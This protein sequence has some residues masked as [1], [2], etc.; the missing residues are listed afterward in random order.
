MAKSRPKHL[1]LF[2]IRLPLPGVISIMHRVFGAA[3]F[4]AIPL[5]LYAMQVSLESPRSFEAL[6]TVLAHPFW[7]LIVVGLV[8]AYLHHF[9][10]GIRYLAIDLDYGTDLGPA[11][12]SATAVV[13]ASLALTF[14][15]AVWIW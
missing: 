14:L 12:A 5:V 8:W 2:Q 1:N 4:L 10:A 13:A 9:F 7:K 11:R 3:L 6:K 15:I